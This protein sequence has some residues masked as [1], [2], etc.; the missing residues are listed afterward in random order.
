MRVTCKNVNCK[1]YYSLK[2]GE[3]CEA[4]EVCGGYMTNKKKAEKSTMRCKNCEY[5]K[6][7]YEDGMSKYHYECTQS[8]NGRV[9]L[10]VETRVCD[11]RI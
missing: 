6:K 2:T 11:V 3:H 7:I 10:F 9:I 4:E 5:C 1:H 8:G